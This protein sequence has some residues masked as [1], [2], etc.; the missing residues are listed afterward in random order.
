[1]AG[2]QKRTNKQIR[3]DGS[4]FIMETDTWKVY[5]VFTFEAIKLFGKGTT[6]CLTWENGEDW[7]LYSKTGRIVV[8]IK[9]DGDISDR[10]YKVFGWFPTRLPLERNLGSRINKLTERYGPHHW[11]DIINKGYVN[12]PDNVSITKIS[13]YPELYDSQDATNFLP[14]YF[15]D[16]G[17]HQGC[18]LHFLAIWTAWSVKEYHN[19]SGLFG[20][21]FIKFLN[22]NPIYISVSIISFYEFF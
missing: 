15:D 8:F 5:E 9:K 19:L 12:S 6:W 22:I 1:M 13:H 14:Y 16:I 10:F 18:L 17:L 3:E 21:Q 20:H 11:R 2:K 7:D 4:Q